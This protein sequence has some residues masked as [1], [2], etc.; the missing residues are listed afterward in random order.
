MKKLTILLFVLS[1]GLALAQP[2]KAPAPK[3]QALTPEDEEIKKVTLEFVRAYASVAS[4][5]KNKDVFLNFFSKNASNNFVSRGLG[6]AKV[7][8]FEGSY[9][10][11]S[12]FLDGLIANEDYK[13]NYNVPEGQIIRSKAIGDAGTST[14][15]VDYETFNAGKLW[16]KG[17]ETVSLLFRKEGGQWKVIYFNAI[18]IEDQKFQG[19]CICEFFQAGGSQNYLTKTTVPEGKEY[20]DK[21]NNFEFKGEGNDR[22]VKSGANTY[23]WLLSG[24]IKSISPTGEEVI[25]GKAGDKEMVIL[26]IIKNMYSNNCLEVR[27]R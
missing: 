15:I 17:T 27:K 12:E 18:A 8:N 3:S 2:K 22:I 5:K 20:S 6:A 14:Y 26:E 13:I 9:D 16:T 7:K 24:E 25:I 23:R 4:E 19:N 21:L 10:A 11:M 1:A